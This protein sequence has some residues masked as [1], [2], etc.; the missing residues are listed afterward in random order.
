VPTALQCPPALGAVKETVIYSFTGGA[1]GGGPAASLYA[2]SAGNLYTTTQGGTGNFGTVV[3][4]SPPPKGQKAWTETTLYAFGAL[5]DGET[6]YG[7]LLADTNGN[8]YLTT[9][10][11]GTANAGTVVELSPPQSG[12]TAWTESILYNFQGGT[13]AGSPYAGLIMDSAGN[14]YTPTLSGAYGAGTIFELS[15]PQ[16]GQTAWTGTILHSFADNSTDGGYPFGDLVADSAGNIYATASQGG[17]AN[18]HCIYG[19]GAVVELSPPPSGSTTWGYDVLYFLPGSN[20]AEGPIARPFLD[21]LGNLYVT[22][23][24][25]LELSPPQSGQTA[26]S[27]NVLYETTTNA[28]LT[29]NLIMD[30][31]GNFYTNTKFGGPYGTK[32]GGNGDGTAVELSPPA[33]GQTSWTETTLHNFGKGKDGTTPLGGLTADSKGNLYTTAWSG[34]AHGHGAIIKLAN[35]GY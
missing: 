34:G 18:S 31:A 8:F 23:G 10:V 1:D 7:D 30:P 27:A 17:P 5:P 11:G 13:Q 2:D 32:H 9:R 26:W 24:S 33:A 29:G 22:A 20:G 4:L 3:K 12:Q 15:P 35:T 21:S 14:L 16:S 28:G 25:L 6:P 19:C